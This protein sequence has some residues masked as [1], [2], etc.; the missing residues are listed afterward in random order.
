MKYPIIETIVNNIESVKQ[1]K[2]HIGNTIVSFYNRG[3]NCDITIEQGWDLSIYLS[4]NKETKEFI[5]IEYCDKI[6]TIRMKGVFYDEPV[7]LI[8]KKVTSIFES[9]NPE[10]EIVHLQKKL[11]ERKRTSINIEDVI[12][13]LEKDIENFNPKSIKLLWREN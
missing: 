11:D 2:Y 6:Q 13:D 4:I 3:E 8:M 9:Y 12:K 7:D 1:K 5:D 10:T